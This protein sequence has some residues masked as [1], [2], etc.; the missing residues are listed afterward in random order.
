MI[1]NREQPFAERLAERIQRLETRLVVGLDPVFERIPAALR[2]RG[3]EEGI[4]E[5][6]RG[7]LEAVAER[8]CAVKPQIAFFERHGW[9]GWRALQGTLEAA[10]ALDVPVILDAKRGDIGSTARA[11]ADALLGDDPETPGPPGGRRAWTRRR[12]HSR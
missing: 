8:V 3:P 4:R 1:P 12:C 2:E 11:Y 7:V 5:Y 6:C 10:A 9:R